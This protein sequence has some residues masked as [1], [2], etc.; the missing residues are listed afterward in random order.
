MS[1]FFE[2]SSAKSASASE[3]AYRL[4]TLNTQLRAFL[5]SEQARNGDDEDRE[6]PE[7]D[8]SQPHSRFLTI[9]GAIC[10]VVR[11]AAAAKASDL[12]SIIVDVDHLFNEVMSLS[13]QDLDMF[14]FAPSFAH[15]DQ[16]PLIEDTGKPLF[17]GKPSV[18]SA[19]QSWLIPALRS[20]RYDEIDTLF[21]V[22]DKR[23]YVYSSFYPTHEFFLNIS[24]VGQPGADLS[25]L[26]KP[27]APWS[28]TKRPH[29]KSTR[30][31]RFRDF[32]AWTPDS[33]TPIAMA[34]Y[35]ARCEITS[36]DI[37][38]PVQMTLSSGGSCLAVTGTGGWKQRSPML[39]YFLLN[40]NDEPESHFLQPGLADIAYHSTIDE[41]RKLILVADSSRIKSYA[42]G[43]L[44]GGENFE[45]PLPTHTMDTNKFEGPL[46]MLSNDRLI[47]AGRGS[48]GVW[49]IDT[50][51]THGP[52]GRARVGSKIKNSELEDTWRDDPESIERSRGVPATTTL[53]FE[54][55]T[56]SPGT[57]HPHPSS[58]GVMLCT[59]DLLQQ[60]SCLALDL[61]HGGKILTRY[62]GHGGDIEDFSTSTA[63]SNV[64]ATAASDSF[65]RLFDI[66]QPLP[67]MTFNA[68]N[69]DGACSAVQLA[70]PDGIPSE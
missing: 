51:P 18:C 2:I 6:D 29:P 15:S 40:K 39:S 58:Q 21:E 47:R 56:L 20:R 50:L 25:G 16:F 35:E 3:F 45:D 46:V 17:G 34:V 8:R 36:L 66:R 69:R 12:D 64:F 48:A 22:H 11:D 37:N 7:E 33:S 49:N 68:Q 60:M 52:T 27:A 30:L 57:W 54:D 14:D 1:R 5:A 61:E 55:S 28:T 53:T 19:F 9:M 4:D 41:Q 70:H 67:V 63:D 13:Y 31:S 44:N 23:V 62:L 59:G 42:W 38:A 10:S 26:P 43:A 65:A 32:T 24:I